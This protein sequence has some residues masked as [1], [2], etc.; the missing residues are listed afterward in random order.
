MAQVLCSGEEAGCLLSSEGSTSVGHPG[1][2]TP[3]ITPV[4]MLAPSSTCPAPGSVINPGSLL[5]VEAGDTQLSEPWSLPTVSRG[6]GG[7]QQRTGLS[8]AEGGAQ[9]QSLREGP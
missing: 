3:I 9:S 8:E 6:P 2:P 1:V 4:I 5:G 7:G